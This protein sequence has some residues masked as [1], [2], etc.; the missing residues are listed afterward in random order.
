VPNTPLGL[1]YISPSASPPRRS[2]AVDL[3]VGLVIVSWLPFACGIINLLVVA[4]SYSRTIT[5]SHTGGAAFFLAGAIVV[6]AAGLVRLM[7]LRHGSGVLFAVV[8][9]AVQLAVVTCIGLA[10]LRGSNGPPQGGPAA[11]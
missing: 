1:D 9:L 7:M 6:S 2:R 10:S 5:Q 11:W 4:N 8:V 3:A